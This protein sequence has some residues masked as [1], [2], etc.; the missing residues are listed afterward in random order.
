MRVWLDPDK[1]NSYSL[2]VGDVTSAL[3]AY[4]VE[5]S[6]GQLGGAPAVPGQHLNVAIVVQ[7]LL[8]T[9]DEFANIPIRINP[10]GS[11]VR[12]KDIGRT[13]LGTERADIVSGY[14]G[15]P[16]AAMKLS[17]SDLAVLF[18]RA[19]KTFVGV[20]FSTRKDG[21]SFIFEA[22]ALK[23]FT[24][25]VS[26][27]SLAARNDQ[28]VD[29]L[30]LFTK[31]TLHLAVDGVPTKAF[32]GIDPRRIIRLGFKGSSGPC[33]V[34]PLHIKTLDGQSRTESFGIQAAVL[35]Y[36]AVLSAILLSGQALLFLLL[37]KR[38]RDSKNI[39]YVAFCL[40]LVLVFTASL[41]MLF[42]K[43]YVTQYPINSNEQIAAERSWRT[44][45]EDYIISQLDAQVKQLQG[46]LPRIL[47]LGSS[48]T[49]G[50]GATTAKDS[51][52]TL[53]QFFG[54][55]QQE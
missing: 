48:Q 24:R 12:I 41:L 36:A 46:N 39:F 27:P 37:Y 30:I 50:S 6:A 26:L 23:R 29:I 3:N 9:P 1:L 38:K 47:C 11:V 49:E 5:V 20:K 51:M 53:I 43:Y 28:P 40:N 45:K 19:D 8:Q 52:V 18:E 42:V 33:S 17:G 22:D 13:E 54:K 31:D 16:S 35:R 14:N 7:H 21:T 44:S 4:N 10:D 25:K 15:Q 2:T 55:N 34:G 32:A